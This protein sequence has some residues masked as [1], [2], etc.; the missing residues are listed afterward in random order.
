[1][2][3]SR[4]IHCRPAD[5]FSSLLRCTTSSYKLTKTDQ[6]SMTIRF[7]SRKS[8]LAAQ[9]GPNADGTIITVLVEGKL[10]QYEVRNLEPARRMEVVRLLD[11]VE[12]DLAALGVAHGGSPAPRSYPDPVVHDGPSP[13]RVV[14]AIIGILIL[15]SGVVSVIEELQPGS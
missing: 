4:Q 15:I 1:M 13:L 14:R 11:A 6:S 3:Y 12:A 8:R 10:P 5:A 7:K 2:K 9:V